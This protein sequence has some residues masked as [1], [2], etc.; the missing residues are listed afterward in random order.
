MTS[1][2]MFVTDIVTAVGREMDA[3]L[4][5]EYIKR[6]RAGGIQVLEF[7]PVNPL[8]GNK[9]EW[10]LNNRDHRKLL[11]VDGRIVESGSHAVLMQRGGDYARM[12][13][14]QADR[15]ASPRRRSAQGNRGARCEHH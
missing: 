15:F 5:W 13:R 4:D 3:G 10:L 9:K 11:L 14:L 6:L 2:T 12:F 8:A 1:A 7:N